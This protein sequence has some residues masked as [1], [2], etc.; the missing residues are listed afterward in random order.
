VI[1]TDLGNPSSS[2]FALTTS[3]FP[4]GALLGALFVAPWLAN[5]IGRR[6]FFMVSSPLFIIGGGLMMACWFLKEHATAALACLIAGRFVAGI[7]VG[8]ASVIAPMYLSE[9]AP[10]RLRGAFGSLVQFA[11]T[12]G[13]LVVEGVSV[14]L[15]NSW[16]WIFAIVAGMGVL[17]LLVASCMSRSPAFVLARGDKAA[18]RQIVCKNLGLRAGAAGMI[19]DGMG[20]GKDADD[21]SPPPSVWRLLSSPVFS[22]PLILC[23]LMMVAQQMSGINAVF[24]F[25]AQFFDKAGVDATTG[26]LTAAGINIVA[27]GVAVAVIELFGR[28]LLLLAS[29]IGMLVF[30]IGLTVTLVLM[31]HDTPGSPLPTISI[32]CVGLYVTFFEMGLGP[33]PWL[34]GA[35]IFPEKPRATAMSAAAGVNWIFTFIVAQGFPIVNETLQ[36][37]SFV[38]FAAALLLAFVYLLFVLPETRGRMP[39]EVLLDMG[40]DVHDDAEAAGI[41]DGMDSTADLTKTAGFDA[42]GS[43]GSVNDARAGAYEDGESGIGSDMYFGGT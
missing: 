40:L 31:E 36:S 13:I 29:T 7:A 21:E 5:S 43:G 41:S 3:L 39:E 15:K 11:V 2:V 12:G 6:G 35:E 14:P 37:F 27:T 30:A 24:F 34:I 1:S 8:G 25:S 20:A 23:M 42:P 22:K 33:I 9:I 26:S 19:I 38:P 16:V 10:V 28:R 17:Q 18:A 4:V 32:V